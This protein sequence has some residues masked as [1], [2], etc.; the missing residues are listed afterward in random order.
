MQTMTEVSLCG[1]CIYMDANGWDEELAGPLPDPAPM[2]LLEGWFISP[3]D[4]DHICEGHF[5]WSPCNGCG[6][7]D[8]GTRYCYTAVPACAACAEAAEMAA[9]GWDDYYCRKHRDM[10]IN[11]KKSNA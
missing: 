5:S 10:A 8:G 1:D 7:P 6:D 2:S 11:W 9:L 4:T 3:N